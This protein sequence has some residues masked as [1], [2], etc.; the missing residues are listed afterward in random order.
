MKISKIFA[1]MSALAI[2]ATMA[3]SASAAVTPKTVDSLNPCVKP[4]SGDSSTV[5][6]WDT[7][8]RWNGGWVQFY[9]TDNNFAGDTIT[10][11]IDTTSATWEESKDEETGEMVSLYTAGNYTALRAF[12]TAAANQEPGKY[13]GGMAEGSATGDFA[14]TD[15]N[16]VITLTITGDQFQ[17]AID[18]GDCTPA[19]CKDD[20]GNVY[21]YNVGFNIQCGH[22]DNA[23]M[24]C[25]ISGSNLVETTFDEDGNI[26]PVLDESNDST[27]SSGTSSETSSTT[28]SSSSAASS[29]SSA[30]SSS[31]KS[32]SANNTS[33]KSNNAATSTAT[34]S[35]ASDNTN[36][37]TG[38]TAGIALAGIALAGAALVVAKKK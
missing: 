21:A 17:A 33:T 11:T 5:S 6:D 32:G 2:A 18:A 20:D 16:G 26:V 31:S 3:V 15:D 27:T 22:Y 8:A 24:T 29:S 19:E 36:A 13:E 38:A 10:F 1:G 23:K 25:T 34:S 35:T 4:W 9:T 30:A 37:G 28:S 14:V 7:G 12:N